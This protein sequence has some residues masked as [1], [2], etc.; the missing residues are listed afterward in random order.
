VTTTTDAT[1][2]TPARSGTDTDTETVPSLESAMA[3]T[4]DDAPVEVTTRN[5]LVVGGGPAG[6]MLAYLLAR[7]GVSVTL[8]E[9]HRDFERDFRGDTVHPSTL[10]AI[11][12]LGLSEKLHALPHAKMRAMRIRTPDGERTMADF[13]RVRTKFPYIMILHQAR[14]LDFL[15]AEAARYPAFQLVM[16]AT[17]QRLVEENGAVAGVRYR[18]LEN[19]W[20]EVRAP[21]TVAADG[22]HSKV[23]ALAGFEPRKSS[24]PMDVLWT[25]LPKEPGDAGDEGTIYVGGGNFLVTFDRGENWMVGYVY[26]KGG[27]QAIRSAGIGELVRHLGEVVPAWKDR[28]ARHVTDWKQCPVLAVESSRLPVWHKPGLLLIGD[29]AHVMSPVGGVGINYAIQDAIE[30]ANQLAGKLKAGTVTEADLAAIQ[31]VR[32][33]PVKVIQG[34]QKAIQDQ[35][36]AAGLRQGASFRM[37]LAARLLTGTPGLRWILPTII[38]WGVRPARVKAG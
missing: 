20:H 30:T 14:F 26:L 29:A 4:A 24:P 7:A 16:G 34:V 38:G 25:R 28:F 13:R 15:A 17:V 32:E 11:D 19:R 8:L 18:D 9:S 12:A 37:P 3:E 36:V 22:W 35:I 5:C 2:V 10:E 21:L 27:F 31:K 33:W 1:K 23:R 6:V